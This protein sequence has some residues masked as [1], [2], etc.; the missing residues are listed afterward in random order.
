MK[1]ITILGSKRESVGK[2]QRPLMC[3]IGTRCN[4][5]RVEPVHFPE[6]KAL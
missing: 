1:S 3:L 6:E 2:R 4:L 5:R